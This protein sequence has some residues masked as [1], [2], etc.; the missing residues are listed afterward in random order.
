MTKNITPKERLEKELHRLQRD[1]NSHRLLDYI[2]GDTSEEE[3]NRQAER[4]VKLARFNE[5]L[6]TLHESEFEIVKVNNCEY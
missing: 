2:P 5:I 1:L 6:E 3:K 4:A